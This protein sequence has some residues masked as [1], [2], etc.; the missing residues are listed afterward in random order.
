MSLRDVLHSV[1]VAGD[2][3]GKGCSTRRGFGGW[4]SKLHSHGTHYY[5]TNIA[6]HLAGWVFGYLKMKGWKEDCIK[7]LIKQSFTA[8][9]CAL[10]EKSSWD[11]KTGVVKSDQI[12]E[13]EQE[14]LEIEQLWVDMTLLNTCK[15][16]DSQV[17]DGEMVAFDWAAGGS[18][19]T[20]TSGKQAEPAGDAESSVVN[21]SD[22]ESGS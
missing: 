19:K 22:E 17:K 5:G 6:A 11:R 3:D 2:I 4:S 18:I 13:T 15:V 12:D 1:K 8:L 14:L 9:A 16:E 21:S 10:S 7:L 20:M